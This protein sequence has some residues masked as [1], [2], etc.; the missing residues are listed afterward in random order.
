MQ[1]AAE[2]Y[3]VGL[4]EDTNICAVHAKRV[5]IMTKDFHLARRIRGERNWRSFCRYFSKYIIHVIYIYKVFFINTFIINLCRCINPS[6]DLQALMAKK[7]SWYWSCILPLPPPILLDL[8]RLIVLLCI[9]FLSYF[10][11]II[12]KVWYERNFHFSSCNFGSFVNN[13]II[14]YQSIINYY[15]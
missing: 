10:F 11:G 14:Y 1:E 3:L 9:A 4:F 12:F 7:K 6:M 2:S 5:T 15:N 8:R 13:L